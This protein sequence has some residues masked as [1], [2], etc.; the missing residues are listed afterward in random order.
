[1]HTP[2]VYGTGTSLTGRVTHYV[3][4]FPS[5]DKEFHR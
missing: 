3:A 5:P 4:M 1:M 2:M